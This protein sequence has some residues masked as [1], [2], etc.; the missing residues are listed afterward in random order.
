MKNQNR[1]FA[2]MLALAI[3]CPVSAHA[4]SENSLAKK[5]IRAARVLQ[6]VATAPDKS[7]P[8]S[9][10]K[11]AVCIATIPDVVRA[12]FGFGAQGGLGMVSC[13]TATGWSNPSYLKIVGGS[14]GFEIG[15]SA[16]DTVLVF[17][18][19]NAVQ[20]LSVNNFTLGTEA[21]VAAGPLGRDLQAET[22]YQL[23]AEIVSYSRARGLF[24]GIAL[25]GTSVSV[26]AKSNRKVYQNEMS[27]QD[28]LTSD[29]SAAPEAVIPYVNALNTF[30]P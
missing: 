3:T 2:A 25:T 10:L 15:V 7:I 21:T 24:A 20:R 1:V 11:K 17:V 8:L 4:V 6:E 18:S 12:A 19:A 5:S 22:D 23:S 16:M 26:D 9:L 29:G 28:L 14:W 30:A 27:P 13:R